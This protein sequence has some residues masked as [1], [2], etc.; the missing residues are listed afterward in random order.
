MGLT[1][2]PTRCTATF[3]WTLCIDCFFLS[4][5]RH[6]QLGLY[7]TWSYQSTHEWMKPNQNLLLALRKLPFSIS[8]ENPIRTF[9]SLFKGEFVFLFWL[10]KKEPIEK[11]WSIQMIK[12]ANIV[13]ASLV[14][15][16]RC[17]PAVFLFIFSE[18]KTH[19]NLFLCFSSGWQK[20]RRKKYTNDKNLEHCTSLVRAWC[21]APAVFLFIFSEKW[22]R[23]WMWWSSQK[24]K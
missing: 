12:T 2:I 13:C 18:K 7:A 16:W 1:S 3:P 23:G 8:I 20:E 6:L 10:S 22:P 24:N 11:K 14:Q 21:C 9:T 19:I 15:A 5:R 17:A 4:A